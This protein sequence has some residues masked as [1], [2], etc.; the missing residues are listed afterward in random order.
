[1]FDEQREQLPPVTADQVLDALVRNAIWRHT[2]KFPYKPVHWLLRY[3]TCELDGF[4][5]TFYWKGEPVLRVTKR[6]PWHYPEGFNFD[7]NV[8][9]RLKTTHQFEYLGKKTEEK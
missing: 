8:I 3:L 9:C 1:M 5:R 6:C 7:D 4:E 2:G